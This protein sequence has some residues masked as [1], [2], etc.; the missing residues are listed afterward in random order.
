MGWCGKVTG[1]YVN[2]MGR[3][4]K[5]KELSIMEIG[6][7]VKVMVWFAGDGIVCEG[8]VLV[9]KGD[10]WCTKVTGWCAKEWYNA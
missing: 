8:K 4:V 3:C 1:C 2:V 6:W 9:F 10:G 5:E 7:C